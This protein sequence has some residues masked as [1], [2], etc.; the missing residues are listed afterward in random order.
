MRN[1]KI[2]NIYHNQLFSTK[3]NIHTSHYKLKEFD[4]IGKLYLR[5]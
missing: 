5:T 2:K 3:Q 4:G 1:V